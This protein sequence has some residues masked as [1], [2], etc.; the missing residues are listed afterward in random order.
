MSVL[1]VT[2]GWEVR[3]T[4]TWAFTW[5]YDQS[6]Q[7]RLLEKEEFP[8]LLGE[9]LLDLQLTVLSLRASPHVLCLHL[10]GERLSRPSRRHI[11]SQ[12]IIIVVTSH[13]H[14][15]RADKI[16]WGQVFVVFFSL[17]E[18]PSVICIHFHRYSLGAWTV[19]SFKHI[20]FIKWREVLASFVC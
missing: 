6:R 4:V 11:D 14:I 2:P 13:C 17:W 16:I 20:S 15:Y 5:H 8:T 18:S 3:E 9:R 19:T 7:Y 1:V 12:N 10:T